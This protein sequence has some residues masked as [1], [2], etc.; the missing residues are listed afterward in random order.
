MEKAEVRRAVLRARRAGSRRE[1]RRAVVK[2]V[3][4]D[5]TVVLFKRAMPVRSAGLDC[6][7][8]QPFLVGW[9]LVKVLCCA[10]S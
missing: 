2:R 3:G 7:I 1:V 9:P 6:V 8:M 4:S 5:E 10:Y